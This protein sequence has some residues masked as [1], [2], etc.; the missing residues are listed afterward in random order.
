MPGEKT[1][2]W[3]SLTRSFDLSF[4]PSIAAQS[5][6]RS[7]TY[8][9]LVCFVTSL[10]LS[11]KYT[12]QFNGFVAQAKVWVAAH[13]NEIWP[14][15]LNEIKV[16]NGLVSSGTQQP[17]THKWGDFAFVLDTTGKVQSLDEYKNGILVTKSKA[18]FK[19]KKSDVESDLKEYDLSKVQSF[20]IRQGDTTKGIIA[21]VTSGKKTFGLGLS[22][23]KPWLKLIYAVVFSGLLIW[24]FIY[25]LNAKTVFAL[26]FAVFALIINKIF[27]AGLTY[28]K[29]LNIAIYALTPATLVSVII[30]LTG[31]KAPL[32]WL[33]HLL[34]FGIYL[35][36]GI[37]SVR[38][39]HQPQE[40]NA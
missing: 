36:L 39:N 32:L 40:Q 2:H 27:K 29:L 23:I 15:G 11:A 1:G 38:D 21:E 30:M 26:V 20:L 35:V 25:Y 3:L 14:K 17:F 34:F 9:L 5:F 13:I 8:L 16:E 10:L 33:L 37:K 6:W 19:T 28:A 24:F 31:F 18:I 7:L 12:V 22:L 4:Y